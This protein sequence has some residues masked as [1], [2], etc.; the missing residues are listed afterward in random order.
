VPY[1]TWSNRTIWGRSNLVGL[2]V[3]KDDLQEIEDAIKNHRD[4]LD[5]YPHNFNQ[6]NTNYPV[7][8]EGKIV[9]D[10]IDDIKAGINSFYYGN[11]PNSG[12]VSD[13]K[14]GDHITAEDISS[15][16][17]RV[18][19]I[20]TN[21]VACDTCQFST[22]TARW[23][24]RW[25]TRWVNNW[26]ASWTTKWTTRWDNNWG[27]NWT[28]RWDNNWSNSWGNSW[29]GSWGSSWNNNWGANWGTHWNSRWGSSWGGRWG[30]RWGSSWSSK[31]S[32]FS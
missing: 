15:L 31:S 29:G 12:L 13:D 19:H 8:K 10:T 7:T 5:N 16:R 17:D 14:T 22:W 11:N 3:K 21:C 4:F 28:T 26:G 27:A 6:P 25:T 20:E 24:T 1:K 18:N 2:I 30:S 9:Y 32:Y 23:S